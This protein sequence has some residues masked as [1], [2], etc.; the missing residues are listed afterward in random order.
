RYL[1]ANLKSLSPEQLAA[2]LLQATGQLDAERV[3]QGKKA[4]EAS[5]DKF[6]AVSGAPVVRSFASAPGNAE[7]F[8]ARTDQALFLANGGLVRGW[9][10]RRPG[11]LTDHL[12]ALKADD[13]VAGDL[14]LSVLTRQ[15]TAEEG[16]DVADYLRGRPKDRAAAL[17]EM[18]WG[19]LASAEF[20]FN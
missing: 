18:A 7:H 16:K 15:P 11:N 5:L 14:Y 13:A 12:L 8:D 10:A 17:Q 19:L 2:S 20:R 1:A 6:V 3:A 4:T 9:L